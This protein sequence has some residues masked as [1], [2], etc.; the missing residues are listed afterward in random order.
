MIWAH[1]SYQEPHVFMA[2]HLI[3]FPNEHIKTA[4]FKHCIHWEKWNCGYWFVWDKHLWRSRQLWQLPVMTVWGSEAQ[5]NNYIQKWHTKQKDAEEM[6][7]RV[8][9]GVFLCGFVLGLWGV[10]WVAIFQKGWSSKWT[11]KKKYKI[12]IFCSPIDKKCYKTK[13]Y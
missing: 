7:L 1:R 10:F 6:S 12:F 11:R 5:E 8:G 13:H 2:P 9:L 4:Y 3:F